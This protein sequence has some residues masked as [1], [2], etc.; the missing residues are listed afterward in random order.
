MFVRRLEQGMAAYI[1]LRRRIRAQVASSRPDLVHVMYG[2]IM[3]RQA[4]HAVVGRPVVVTF[5][6]SDL[7]GEHAAGP[8]REVAAWYRRQG[9][10]SA[11]RR[12][13]GIVVVSPRLQ[14]ALSSDRPVEGPNH[15]MRYR[16][17]E[18][19]APKRG[20]MPQTARL[21]PRPL[22]RALSCTPG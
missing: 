6:G 19:H 12:A 5:H 21:E 14:S 17:R 15:S 10:P 2:G 13:N 18:V 11:A 8:V 20:G 16:P 7:L 4:T 9:V 3:A 1:G 22:S